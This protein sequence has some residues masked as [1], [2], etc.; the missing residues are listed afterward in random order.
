MGLLRLYKLIYILEHQVLRRAGGFESA[1]S[2]GFILQM[3]QLRAWVLDKIALVQ[4]EA[5]P[6]APDFHP[7]Q[8]HAFCN[9]SESN[10][11]L[12]LLFS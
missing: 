8:P 12:A 7:R 5:E 3:W 10:K 11:L 6:W 1:K 2:S 4:L 9:P